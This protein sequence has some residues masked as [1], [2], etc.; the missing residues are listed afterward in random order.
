[1]TSVLSKD[2]YF[3]KVGYFF[4][5]LSHWYFFIIQNIILNNYLNNFIKLNFL[6]IS[7]KGGCITKW[8][9]NDEL[10]ETM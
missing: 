4:S 3:N 2:G 1:M 8:L 6:F 5:F 9:I 7:L 10:G